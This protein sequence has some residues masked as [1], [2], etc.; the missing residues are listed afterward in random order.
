MRFN[1]PCL[2][3][4]S[5]LNPVYSTM[6]LNATTDKRHHD[7]ERWWLMDTCLSL[8]I[9]FALGF[10]AGYVNVGLLYH[11]N[12]YHLSYDIKYNTIHTLTLFLKNMAVGAQH[13]QSL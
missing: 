12:I 7:R 13:R 6:D 8:K 1:S 2:G 11:G 4:K 5:G 9:R 3:T 10:C